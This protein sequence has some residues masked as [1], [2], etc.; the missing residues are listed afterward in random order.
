MP[1]LH[2]A[3]PDCTCISQ[4]WRK[5]REYT[6]VEKYRSILPPQLR[7]KIMGDLSTGLTCTATKININTQAFYVQIVS[8]N[9]RLYHNLGEKSVSTQPWRKIGAYSL[10]FLH[11]CAIKSGHGRP[12]YEVNVYSY[13]T[14]YVHTC[15]YLEHELFCC[16][17]E[18]VP[19]DGVLQDFSEESI[20]GLVQLGVIL[21]VDRISN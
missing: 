3:T 21:G 5:I 10:L 18:T 13:S 14:K 11:S 7:N 12:E 19:S 20:Q 1:R 8:H 4:P 16:S 17:T 15:M 9:S 6:T 2:L